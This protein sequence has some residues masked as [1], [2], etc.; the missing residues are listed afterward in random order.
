MTHERRAACV[1]YL[2]DLQ[3]FTWLWQF[4]LWQSFSTENVVVDRERDDYAEIL[5]PFCNIV[6]D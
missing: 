1:D 6:A 5:C 3:T 4:V 2:C